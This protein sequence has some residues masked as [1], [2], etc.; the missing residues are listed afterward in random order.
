MWKR[1]QGL[2]WS[3]FAPG[4]LRADKWHPRSGFRHVGS[5]EPEFIGAAWTVP[6]CGDWGIWERGG[7][8]VPVGPQRW[9]RQWL[10]DRGDRQPQAHVS[11]PRN[12]WGVCTVGSWGKSGLLG[13]KWT[14]Q[15]PG[16]GGALGLYV[17]ACSGC[18][19]R[20]LATAFPPRLCAGSG[21]LLPCFLCQCPWQPGCLLC[22]PLFIPAAEFSPENS[23]DRIDVTS[24]RP[25][26]RAHSPRASHVT[27]EPGAGIPGTGPVAPLKVPVSGTWRCLSTCSWKGGSADR[28][29]GS[30]LSSPGLWFLPHFY[31]QISLPLPPAPRDRWGA[32]WFWLDSSSG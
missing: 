23:R 17:T 13:E 31:V 12:D 21:G 3:F 5:G 16:G 6:R 9:Q 15:S 4:N 7:V 24:H 27:C 8:M 30:D 32:C 20:T 25:S 29:L 22:V 28:L 14:L 11:T 19:S 2:S 1:P 26:D 10:G 18:W